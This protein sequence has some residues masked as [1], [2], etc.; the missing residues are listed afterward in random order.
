MISLRESCQSLRRSLQVPSL[1]V[2]LLVLSSSLFPTLAGAAE[3]DRITV[4]DPTTGAVMFRVTS[5]G[6]ITGS[7]ITTQQGASDASNTA[8]LSVNDSTGINKFVVTADGKIGIGQ[9]PPAYN[10][11]SVSDGV[12]SVLETRTY[13]TTA[14]NRS[15][16]LMNR[17]GGSLASPTT[18][19]NGDWIGSFQ[20]NAYIGSSGFYASAGINFLIDGL[21]TLNQRSPGKIVFQTAPNGGAMTD[22]V[23]VKNDGTVGIGTATPTQELEVNGG[24][25]LNTAIA[26]PACSSSSRGT[27]WV[28][29]GSAN[30]TVQVCVLVGGSLLW[31][32]VALQ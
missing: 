4:A 20:A 10:I 5:A 3:T 24:F 18:M 21:P 23:T 28:T 14:T 27:F 12:S 31:K 19:N 16:L 26:Q 29:Q 1:A 11:S 22:R 9:N 25:R 32:T 7:S 30:D 13:G 15:I 8:K 17:A 6:N 2:S